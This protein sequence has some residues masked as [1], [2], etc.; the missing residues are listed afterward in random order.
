MLCDPIKLNN[1]LQ[2]NVVEVLMIIARLQQK[3]KEVTKELLDD[4][5]SLVIQLENGRIRL[6]FRLANVNAPYNKSGPLSGWS[7]VPAQLTSVHFVSYPFDCSI[8][9]GKDQQN[10]FYMKNSKKADGVY[11]LRDEAAAL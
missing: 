7:Q 6:T 4:S 1:N 9:L 8:G 3:N 11:F 2:I 10:E 5:N